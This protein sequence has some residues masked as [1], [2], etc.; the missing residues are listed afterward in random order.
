M[1]FSSL[2]AYLDP[3]NWQPQQIN[4][5]FI[6]VSSAI[7]P[8]LPPPQQSAPP[9]PPPQHQQPPPH[10]TNG[11]PGTGS[12]SIRPGSMSER[13]RLANIPMPESALKCPRCDSTNT[14]FCYFNNYS[15]SQPRHFCKTCRRYWT[16]GG[17]MR[18]VPVGGGCRRNKRS[19]K[20]TATAKSSPA[21]SGHNINNSNRQTNSNSTGGSNN[22]DTISANYGMNSLNLTPQF[23]P[24]RFMSPLSQLRENFA[25]DAGFSNYMSGNMPSADDQMIGSFH[26]DAGSLMGNIE[27]WKFQQFQFLGGLDPQPPPGAAYQFYSG[28]EEVR[29]K[30]SSSLLSQLASVK[31][32]DHNRPNHTD[33]S[34][35]RE[36]LLGGMQENDHGQWNININN[37]I[38]NNNAVASGGV[39]WTELSSFSSSPT[40]NHLR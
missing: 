31:M 30:I 22:N 36:L 14:K 1:V 2:P 26:G 33:L 35:S 21:S 23:Q 11:G 32:E 24:L 4:H 28:Q 37:N 13:A 39:N 7:N 38:N 15:L 34:L 6:G 10:Q 5:Q 17:A 29:P 8:I 12:G 18:S 16:R 40:S 27:P 25:G 3:S 19:S 20:S 9:P